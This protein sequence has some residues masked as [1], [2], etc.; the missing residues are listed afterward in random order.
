MARGRDGIQSCPTPPLEKTEGLIAQPRGKSAALSAFRNFVMLCCA[1]ATGEAA[2]R[3]ALFDRPVDRLFETVVAPEDLAVF[4][5]EARRAGQAERLGALALRFQLRLVGGLFG[6]GERGL[7]IEADAGDQRAENGAI[8]DRRAL[9]ELGA[10]DAARK[11]R[12]RR[13]LPATAR[14]ARRRG[15]S[16]GTDRGAPAASSGERRCAP[17]RATYSGP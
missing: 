7:R 1:R 2:L 16:A 5:D 13:R 14:R 9:A 6:A 8:R 10:I 11:I 4:G 12:P 17:C 15:C 3:S